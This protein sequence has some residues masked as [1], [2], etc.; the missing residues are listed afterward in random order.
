MGI[1]GERT[2]LYPHPRID[3]FYKC[4]CGEECHFPCSNVDFEGGLN[5]M[6]GKCGTTT[7]VP[8]TIFDRR[9]P[10]PHDPSGADIHADWYMRLK[11]QRPF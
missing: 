10:H 1:F 7:Y 8:P 6:C 4:Q 5:V 3:L 2:R 11:P 9:T